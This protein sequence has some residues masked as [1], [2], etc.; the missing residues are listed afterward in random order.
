M[1]IYYVFMTIFNNLYK[2]KKEV[3]L[4]LLNTTF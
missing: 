4:N 2:V 3:S 1:S